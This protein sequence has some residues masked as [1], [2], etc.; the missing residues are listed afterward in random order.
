MMWVSY[1]YD[2]SVAGN[3]FVLHAGRPKPKQLGIEAISDYSDDDQC[4]EGNLENGTITV[5]SIKH[6]IGSIPIRENAF[7]LVDGLPRAISPLSVAL[8]TEAE[9]SWC[10]AL[11]CIT[12]CRKG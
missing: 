8:K 11:S 12:G 5:C 9:C 4:Y 7:H 3:F 10:G 1:G 6:F 2:G